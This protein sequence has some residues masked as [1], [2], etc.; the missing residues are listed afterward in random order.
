MRRGPRRALRALAALA[1]LPALAAAL[2][3]GFA[4]TGAGRAW[5]GRAAAEATAGGV[6][7][8][9]LSGRFPDRLRLARLELRDGQGPW[10]SADDLALDWSPAGLLGGELVVSR[11]EA[12][13]VALDR[14]PPEEPGPAARPSLPVAVRLGRLAVARLDLGA[15]VAGGRAVS[16]G[17]DGRAELASLGRGRLELGV[18]RLD[19][20]GRYALQGVFDLPRVDARLSLQEPPQGLLA[21]LAGI[22]EA[23]ALSLEATAAGPL[24]AL[25][26]RLVLGFGPLQ[27]RAEGRLDVEHETIAGLAVGAQAPAMRPRPGLSWQSVDLEAQ[28]KGPFARP[29][30]TGRLRIE[31]LE[32]AGAA[33]RTVALD[34]QGNAGRVGLRGGLSG[35][36]L[37]GPKPELLEAAPLAVEAEARLDDA[38]RPVAFALKHPLLGAKGGAETAEPVKLA[39]AVELPDL[40]PY[41]ALGGQDA[42]GRA[43]LDLKLERRGEALRL[44][45]DGTVGVTGGAAPWP[46]LLGGAARLGAEAALR[47]ADLE[48][49]RLALDGKALAVSADGALAANVARFDWK[50]ALN[51]LAAVLEGGS[52]RL[53]ARGRVEGPLDKFSVAAELDGELGAKNLPRGPLSAKVRLDGLP[54]APAGSVAARGMLG[55]APLELE[56]AAQAAAD[57]SAALALNRADWKS[58]HARG[59]LAL[60][61][62]GGLPSGR[63]ELR[64]GNLADLSPL[65]GRPLAGSAAAALESSAAG[66]RPRARLELDAAQAGLP[67]AA[68]AAQ[69]R[70]E[71][72]VADP[73]QRPVLDGRLAL[74][75]VAAGGVAGGSA[76]L[77]LAGPLE[78]LGL[79]L[80]ARAPALA[81]AGMELDAAASLDARAGRLALAGLEARWKNET[82]RLLAPARIA[83]KEGLA[84]DRLRL[85]LREAVLEVAGR[86]APALD[87]EASLKGLDAGL[88]GVFAPG[89]AAAGTLGAEARLSGPPA[90]PAG[91][92]EVEARGLRLL[93]GP[94]RAL[95]PLSLAA[96]ARLSGGLA[97]ID[98]RLEAGRELSLGVRGAAP[99][100]PAGEFDLKALGAADLK[101]LDP[102]L[103]AAGRRARGQVA[104]D[105]ALAGPLSAPRLKGGLRLAGGEVLDYASGL[106]V[107]DIAA[108]LE[109]D[110]GKIRLGKLTGRA[111]PGVLSAA[112]EADLLGEGLPVELSLSARKARP[113]AGDR[114]S[115]DLDADLA[116]RG[117]LLGDLAAAGTVRIR[118]AEIRVP[119]KLPAS[120][121]VLKVARPGEAPPPPPPARDSSIGLDLTLDAPGQIFVRGR[122]L[123]AELGGR[124]RLRGT[125]AAPRPDGGFQMRRGEFSLAG[126]RLVFSKGEVG[127][128]GGSLADPSLDFLAKTASAGVTAFLAVG[129]T[130]GKPK[131]T[132]SS[133]PELPQDEVLAQL[134]FGRATGSLSPMEMVQ[135][136]AALASLS[137][138]APGLGDPLDGVRKTLGLDRLSVGSSLE[139]GR[140]LA[141]GVY[142][143]AKQ[144]IT[145]AGAQ[146]TVQ[147]DVAKGLKVEGAVGT[148]PAGNAQGGAGAN[149]V[150][151]VYQYEY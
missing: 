108:L 104:L 49:S 82:L 53:A 31:R 120:V 51:D 101:L 75:G 109:A 35:L 88:A 80:S 1:G 27:A 66:G 40:K 16:L 59:G 128:T 121:A 150:G 48:L 111:G 145:G 115:V 151:V 70:L 105:A 119:E 68:T 99:L 135:I 84:V 6:R 43:R 97:D 96:S 2:L 44:A 17:V 28:V 63:V 127:F 22:E 38:R 60:P 94:A 18:R 7:L 90:R 129:G 118:R 73:L 91:A 113:L 34:L 95:P 93:D 83:F 140:Y 67:G 103:G 144:G 26:A 130:A 72:A 50:F 54:K 56:L 149:S 13:R 45:V 42:Q 55:G 57:G 77:D 74:E 30:A 143:G 25:D 146:A 106:R 71:L 78:A 29:E 58:A 124:V 12:G 5:I 122:G 89:L 39:L 37:P 132:L 61:R 107:S 81:G 23:Y 46:G 148:S 86:A 33:V 133:N 125:A 32:A 52:G 36:R 139:A 65:L 11:L 117:R 79:R 138:A 9:G 126:Q 64:L 123:D 131:I 19:G 8:E 21:S 24:S 41:A 47:G 136:G 147:I 15:A 14:L 76:A 20:G 62:G 142:L 100:A 85:G 110:G 114:L 112:G 3:V 116:L 102:L 4:N 134:L 69:A 141:P 92:V 98:A 10:L 137:G 87:L